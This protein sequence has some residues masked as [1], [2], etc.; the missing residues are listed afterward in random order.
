MGDEREAGAC[1]GRF[2]VTRDDGDGVALVDTSSAGEVQ[3]GAGEHLCGADQV[4]C[5]DARK[6]ED[7]D[8]S[9]EFSVCDAGDGV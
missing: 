4:E 7:D 5:L 3:R 9:H 6:P 2:A 8:R 1:V